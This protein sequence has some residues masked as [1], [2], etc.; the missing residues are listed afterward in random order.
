M[1]SYKCSLYCLKGPRDADTNGRTFAR[2][3]LVLPDLSP[4]AQRCIKRTVHQFAERLPKPSVP[5]AMVL[6]LDP[7]TKTS[8]KNYLRIP[9]TAEAVT[10]NILEDTNGLLRIEHCVFY[11]AMYANAERGD[12]ATNSAS[13]SQRGECS[14]TSDTELGLLCGKEVSQPTE[15]RPADAT[16]NAKADSL[17]E[18]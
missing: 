10:N 13:S 7:R 2:G 3:Q 17:L 8:A 4:L 15:E 14:S 6:L 9:D 18:E 16:L 1:N 11:R 5:L 12:D